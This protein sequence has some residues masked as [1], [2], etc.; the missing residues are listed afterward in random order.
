M[1]QDRAGAGNRKVTRRDFLKYSLGIGTMLAV[2]PIPARLVGA[3][4]FVGPEP[5]TKN[6]DLVVV[7]HGMAGLAAALAAAETGAKVAVLEKQ[8][9]VLSGGNSRI[10]GGGFCIPTG[11]TGEAKEL[12]ID[13]FMK[14]SGYRAD[15]GLTESLAENILADIDWLTGHGVEFTDPA[16][17]PPY[18][19]N[20]C[21]ATPGWYRGMPKLLD[22]VRSKCEDMG[23]VVY[24]DTKARE[25]LIDSSGRIAG[26][27]AA[28]KD[29]F[30]DLRAVSTVITTGGFA[31]NVQML[32][33]WV[34]ADADE[35][36]VRG[37]KWATGEGHT[38]A[39][40]AGAVL[41]Q[42]AGLDG[43]HVGAVHP[44]NTAA[45]NP[46][47]LL[48]YCVGINR[49]GQRY[50]DESL[51]YVAHGKAAMSQPGL[52]VALVFDQEIADR[53]EG[54]AVIEQFAGYGI[55]PVKADTLEQLAAKINAPAG[56][57]IDTIQKFNAAVKDKQ[58][59]GAE[60]PK[61]DLAFKI[62]AS[63]FY[64]LYPLK[65]GIT[66]TFGGI[67]V[68]A[69]RQALQ[70]DG[71]PIH[72]LYAAGECVGG[73]FLGDYVGGASLTRCLVDG[74]IAGKS[75]AKG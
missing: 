56:A 9:K 49:N 6:Y 41:V 17:F 22:A 62:D 50:V 74:R 66:L 59:L 10:A 13:D 54:K 63:P 36:M 18:H 11:D 16:P 69:N 46:F 15:K 58:A 45:A 27:R 38:M 1:K 3:A 42:M 43:I 7:G 44:K 53:P 75:G 64:A 60:P 70:A 61:K 68:D 32:E 37:V 23:T 30:V 39:A 12:F 34:G 72:G 55:E 73:Y 8:R 57:M 24:Y 33:K 25:L 40:N 5:V 28:T 51:G 67:K 65:P 31:G 71:Q 4:T 47:R 52:E 14:K 20:V 48:P 19:V 26:V 35:S 29:G 21:V 2:A